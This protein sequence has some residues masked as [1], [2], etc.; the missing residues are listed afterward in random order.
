MAEKSYEERDTHLMCILAKGEAF[1]NK[2]PGSEAL[3]RAI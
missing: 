2:G 3:W 1:Q